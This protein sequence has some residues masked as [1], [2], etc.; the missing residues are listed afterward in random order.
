MCKSSN[1][2][3]DHQTS[4]KTHTVSL[5]L[6]WSLFLFQ[7]GFLSLGKHH[8][9]YFNVQ[10]VNLNSKTSNIELA[11]IVEYFDYDF[12]IMY[13]TNLLEKYER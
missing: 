5:N 2:K 3:A 13:L 11:R 8:T 4:V 12:N 9:L 1:G 10:K 6:K 7:T